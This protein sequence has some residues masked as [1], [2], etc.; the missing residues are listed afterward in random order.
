MC[1]HLQTRLCKHC[2]QL[3]S[4]KWE[5]D[6]MLQLIMLCCISHRFVGA[7]GVKVRG[8][9]QLFFSAGGSMA[10]PCWRVPARQA[11][12]SS[13]RPGP[14]FAPGCYLEMESVIAYELIEKKK[15]KLIM[16]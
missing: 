2:K 8:K 16:K 12:V 11:H 10:S 5:M 6:L 14:A 3:P 9:V 1:I 7:A 15:G 4:V 13:L